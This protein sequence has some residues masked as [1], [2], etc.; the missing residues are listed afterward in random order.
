MLIT[1]TSAS[2]KRMSHEKRNAEGKL[3]L[4]KKQRSYFSSI[5]SELAGLSFMR[6]EQLEEDKHYKIMQLSIE[7]ANSRL[8][9]SG[10]K[11][12]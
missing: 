3:S 10:R 2:V 11:E 4:Q 12:Q 1:D 7:S 8:N 5:S 6:K 9:Q